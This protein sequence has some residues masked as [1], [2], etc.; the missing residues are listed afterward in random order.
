M[1]VDLRHGRYQDVMRDVT[2]D[3]LCA[4]PPYSDKVHAGNTADKLSGRDEYER[5]E[6]S[7]E[8]WTRDDVHE[9]VEFWAPRTRGWMACMSCDLLAPF[10]REAFEAAG[11]YAFRPLPC[12]IPGMT[13]RMSG[14][15]P[16]SW[17]VYLSVARPRKA[18]FAK[19]GTLPGAYIAT[20]GKNR[21]ASG[22][23]DQ[24]R[25]GGKPLSLV[26]DIVRDY[27][28]KGDVV[29]DPC[30]GGATTLLAARLEKRIGIGSEQD[31]AAYAQAMEVLTHGYGRAP[32]QE[33]LF[34]AR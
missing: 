33:V 19:W 25:I 32:E 34:D 8:H 29:C 20:K 24:Y 18:A 14:D 28:R 17:S 12:V 31:A 30:A 4:D 22:H 15:G 5:R 6:L 13:V 26:R 23:V 3:L 21:A 9:F 1:S 27:S 2:C 11:L 7:Y 16:S 10:Y